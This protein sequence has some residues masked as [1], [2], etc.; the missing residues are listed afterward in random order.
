MTMAL[1]D[2]LVELEINPLVVYPYGGGAL[3]LDLVA[4][5]SPNRG[6]V[7]ILQ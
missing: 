5:L 7:E 1:G 3:A 2:D 6:Y 4:R